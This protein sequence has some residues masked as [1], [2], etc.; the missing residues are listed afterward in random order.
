[1]AKSAYPQIRRCMRHQQTNEIAPGWSL[2]WTEPPVDF[3]VTQWELTGWV[4]HH[5]HPETVTWDPIVEEFLIP[6]LLLWNGRQ[7]QYLIEV[8]EP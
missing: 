8:R 3:G 2:T 1:M 7:H 4:E 5:P 6:N